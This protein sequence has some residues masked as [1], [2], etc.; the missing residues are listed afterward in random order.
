M[1][2]EPPS[3]SFQELAIDVYF[4][5][6]QQFLIAVDCCTDW[7]E[8]TSMGRHT[9]TSRLLNALLEIFSWYGTPDIV[10]SDQ[11]PQFTS[12]AFKN[13]SQT[14]GFQHITSSPTYPQSNRKAEAAVKSMKKLIAR[15]S[16]GRQ[17]DHS[18]LAWAL[19]QCRNTPSR[20]DEI[21]PA[22]RLLGRPL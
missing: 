21:S 19:L 18:K 14:C 13:I 1:P 5:R 11:G 3:Q 22:Q 15:V 10:W 7:P 6:G 12:Q 4:Y 16:T 2:K 8:I 9:T 20:R 17:I